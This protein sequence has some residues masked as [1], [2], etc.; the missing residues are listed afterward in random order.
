MVHCTRKTSPSVQEEDNYRECAAVTHRSLVATC[1]PSAF[2]EG[3][4][5][6]SDFFQIPPDY[7][8]KY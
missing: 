5:P 7:V 6:M 1:T 2:L 8:V 3:K 4:A